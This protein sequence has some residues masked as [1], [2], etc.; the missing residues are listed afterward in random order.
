MESKTEGV[1]AVERAFLILNAFRREDEA[2]TLHDLAQRTGMYKSTILRLLASLMRFSTVQQLADGR[3]RLGHTVM[4]WGNVYQA[5]LRLEH[6]VVPVLEKL[7]ADTGEGASYFR[8]EGDVRL[9]LYRIDSHRSIRDHMHAGDILPLQSGAAGRVLIEFEPGYTPT[10][11]TSVII[12][13]GEREPDIAA[14]AAP[15]FDREGGVVGSVSVSGPASRFHAATLSS[16]MTA[17][18]DAA[19]S[20]TNRFG[21]SLEMFELPLPVVI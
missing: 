5:S 8:R 2:I 11:V 3:Y 14:V 18:R 9:C 6:V 17:V 21:G 16:H 20:L 4:H 15:V 13:I 19:I 12:S 7:A 1:A 10:P